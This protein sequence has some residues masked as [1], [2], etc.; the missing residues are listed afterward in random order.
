MAVSVLLSTG[1]SFF[2][3]F[4]VESRDT[5]LQALVLDLVF[6]ERVKEFG[7]L[8]RVGTRH[9]E[10]AAAETGGAAG[11]EGSCFTG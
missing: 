5:G 8:G 2:L 10:E 11:A 7:V 9:H 1:L 3:L 6:E 4:A